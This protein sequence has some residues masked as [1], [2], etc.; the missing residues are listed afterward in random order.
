MSLCQLSAL[1]DVNNVYR[2][3]TIGCSVIGKMGVQTSV[4][5]VGLY[6]LIENRF[7]IVQPSENIALL[8]PVR[9]VCIKP[10]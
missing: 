8:L 4:L 10:V 5:M 3:P 9:W 7:N 6:M 1:G 2:I